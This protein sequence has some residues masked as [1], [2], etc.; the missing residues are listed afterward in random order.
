MNWLGYILHRLLGILMVSSIILCVK[1]KSTWIYFIYVIV[2]KDGDCFYLHFFY[3]NCTVCL[4]NKWQNEKKKYK[5]WQ[6]ISSYLF[7]DLSIICFRSIFILKLQ[8]HEN[9]QWE[10]HSHSKHTKLTIPTTV[11]KKW[12]TRRQ[13]NCHH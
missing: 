7:H 2:S 10:P 5:K 11:N 8:K 9:V 3:W 4:H 1:P 13:C 12:Y 6:N